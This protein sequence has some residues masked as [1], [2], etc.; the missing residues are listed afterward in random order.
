M[1]KLY[2]K[3]HEERSKVYQ[4]YSTIAWYVSF[5]III[6]WVLM[7]KS[8]V[9]S[10]NNIP[11]GSMIPT[12]KIGDFLFV[13]RMRYGLHVPFTDINIW[14]YA[15]PERGDIVVFTPPED[16][17]LEGKT[18]VKRVIGIPGDEIFVKDDEIFVNNMAYPVN[19]VEDRGILSDLDYPGVGRGMTVDD[20][21]LFKEKVIEPL[22]GEVKVEHFMMKNANE[23]MGFLRNPQKMFIVPPGSYMVMGDNRDDSDDSR[24]WGYVA[25]EDIHGKVFMIYFSVNWG[26]RFF[27][28]SGGMNPFTNLFRLVSGKLEKV[29]VRWK[30]IGDRIY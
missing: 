26:T 27:Y 15:K 23:N 7:F 14:K 12:L 8:V 16:A 25:S 13:N 18:L 5:A 2:Y 22:T 30:R 29:S 3:Y 1:L 24:N 21:V 20:L 9:L 28:N 11:T 10:A 6:V 4:K 19:E 17:N